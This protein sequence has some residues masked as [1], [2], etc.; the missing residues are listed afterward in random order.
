MFYVDKECEIWWPAKANSK[1]DQLGYGAWLQA[2]PYN[3]GKISFTTIS[4]MRDGYGRTQSGSLGPKA[5]HVHESFLQ[6]P[7]T[8]TPSDHYPHSGDTNVDNSQTS[9]MANSNFVEDLTRS[10]NARIKSNKEAIDIIPNITPSVSQFSTFK[11][12]INEIDVAVKKFESNN[13]PL[14]VTSQTEFTL[15]IIIDFGGDISGKDSDSINDSDEKDLLEEIPSRDSDPSMGPPVPRKWKKLARINTP[16]DS[17]MHQTVLNNRSRGEGE[18]ILLEL[19]N[20]RHQV[21]TA[22]VHE[23]LMVEAVKQPHQSQ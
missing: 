3:P 9:V 19:P 6:H 1:L 20:K 2:L 21:S 8:T 11:S 14:P 5:L 10:L 12:H 18:S 7:V 4:G 23:T 15:P 17:S 22:E 16:S 13:T